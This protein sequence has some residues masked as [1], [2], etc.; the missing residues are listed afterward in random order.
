MPRRILEV[1]NWTDLCVVEGIPGMTGLSIGNEPRKGDKLTVVGH[2]Y[3][4]PLTISEGELIDKTTVEVLDHEMNPL[5][6]ND[7]CDL[8]KNK[9]IEVN[10]GFFAGKYCIDNIMA[11][12]TTV[13]T[14]PG[15]S[16]S[17]VVD[18]LGNLIALVFASNSQTF[19]GDFVVLDDIKGFLKA[20]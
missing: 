11:Y 15:N 13:T 4:R 9:I 17:P 19:Q 1:S 14:F 5:D 16:G 20:Y 8:P 3:L 2:P 6:L 12:E 18:Q 10:E 7:K